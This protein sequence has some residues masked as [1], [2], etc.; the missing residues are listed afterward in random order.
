MLATVLL[1]L[2][3]LPACEQTLEQFR[4][5]VTYFYTLTQHHHRE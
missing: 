3:V 2:A 1:L 5:R 4:P